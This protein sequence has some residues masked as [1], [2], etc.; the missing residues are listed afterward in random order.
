MDAELYRPFE[1]CFKVLKAQGAWQ[2]GKQTW[3]YFF[4]GYFV[5]FLVVELYIAS[6]AVVIFTAKE[7]IDV[8]GP[9]GF[10]LTRLVNTIKW[11]N[12]LIN[13]HSIMSLLESLERTL[14]FARDPLRGKRVELKE[15]VALVYRI[16]VAYSKVVLVVCTV[17]ALK[18]ILTGRQLTKMWFPFDSGIGTIGFWVA[19]AFS[20]VNIFFYGL[21]D[22][23]LAFLPMIFISFAV[24]LIKELAARL[25]DCGDD[26]EFVKCVEIHLMIKELV[27][28][29]Q[30]VFSAVIFVQGFM[31]SIFL[32]ARVFTLSIVSGFNYYWLVSNFALKSY[33]QEKDLSKGFFVVFSLMPITFAMFCNCYF[34]N[35]ISFASLELSPAIYNSVWVGKSRKYR[36]LLIFFMTNASK[37][38]KLS[39]FGMFN[40]DLGI[41]GS[42]LNSAYSLFTLLKSLNK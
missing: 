40:V 6:E 9:L 27:R 41:F 16:F 15:Q 25:K 33:F 29:I 34:C 11:V 4:A 14:V 18:P 19:T 7:L 28:D 24:G 3:R 31:G 35:E 20:N 5:H 38:M 13:F 22:S 42:I 32:C 23:M 17:G 21:N 26:E 37:A 2:D 12:F 10:F 30:K 36:K 39:A 1:L 8:V